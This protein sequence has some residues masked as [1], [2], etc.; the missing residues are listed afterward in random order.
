MSSGHKT[1]EAP[2]RAEHVLGDLM[3]RLTRLTDAAIDGENELVL[4]MAVEL[5]TDCIRALEELAAA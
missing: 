3:A 5:E 2:R 1:A 4:A